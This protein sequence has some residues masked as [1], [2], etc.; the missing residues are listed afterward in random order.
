[1]HFGRSQL[2]FE[3]QGGPRSAPSRREVL[4]RRDQQH[5]ESEKGGPRSAPSRREV[6]GRRVQQHLEK[7]R[8][9]GSDATCWAGVFSST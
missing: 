6:L 1:M 4:R 8:E 9:G 2:L 5:L 3:V 7:E